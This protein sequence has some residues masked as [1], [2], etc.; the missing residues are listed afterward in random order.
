LSTQAILLIAAIIIGVLY[1][2]RRRARLRA[3][4]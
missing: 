4:D 2:L 1:L 3:D